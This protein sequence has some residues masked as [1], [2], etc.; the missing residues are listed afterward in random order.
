MARTVIQNFYRDEIAVCYGC[1]KNNPHE[2]RIRTEWDGKEG[3][4]RFTPEPHHTAFPGVVYGGLIACL[5]DCH[6]IGTAVAAAYDR[7]NR[8]PGTDP[9]I[10]FVTGNLNVQY[11]APTPI[12]TELQL[13]SRIKEMHERKAVVV[14]TVSADGKKCA[15]GEVVAVRAALA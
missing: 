2:L 9:E 4:F 7:E 8:A 12:E 15:E 10:L 14:C 3:T 6:S 5:I 11:L 13:R 1:G